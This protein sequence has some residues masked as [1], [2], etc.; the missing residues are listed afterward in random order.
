MAASCLSIPQY[1]YRSFLSAAVVLFVLVLSD[2]TCS[3]FLTN[4]PRTPTSSPSSHVLSSLTPQS[5]LEFRDGLQWRIDQMRLEE[6]W[7]RPP[8]PNLTPIEFIESI[9]KGISEVPD[10]GFHTLLRSS[11]IR[12]RS[13]IYQ[14]IGAPFPAAP[15]ALVA[16]ALSSTLSKTFDDNQFGILLSHDSY[17]CEFP[18]DVFGDDETC[19]VECQ[20][21]SDDA[22]ENLWVVMGWSLVYDTQAKSWMLDGIEW[23]DFREQ[24]RPGLGRETWMRQLS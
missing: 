3:A 5:F 7:D 2:Y 19:W 20:L 16:S 13:E 22:D 9:L 15:P 10:S 11:T 12:W 1:N 23:Q 24:F 6:S 18:S 14:S 17:S 8:N 21:R 4:L